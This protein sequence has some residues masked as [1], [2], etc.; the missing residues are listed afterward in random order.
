MRACVRVCVGVRLCGRV[1]VGG[2]RLI[3][4]QSLKVHVQHIFLK[5]I[6]IKEFYVCCICSISGGFFLGSAV[7]IGESMPQFS[8]K[9]LV[10]LLRVGKLDLKS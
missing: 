2:T 6:I 3:Y 4:E 7:L 5:R 10:I 9:K 8:L 1:L